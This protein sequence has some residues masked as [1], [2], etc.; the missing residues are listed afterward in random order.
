MQVQEGLG[1]LSWGLGDWNE[2]CQGHREFPI[3]LKGAHAS[4]FNEQA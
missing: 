2:V 4:S 1:C 3:G